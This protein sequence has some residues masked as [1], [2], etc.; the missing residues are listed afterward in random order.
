SRTPGVVRQARSAPPY[1]LMVST[2]RR[3]PP[4]LRAS[5]CRV[6]EIPCC[7]QAEQLRGWLHVCKTPLGVRPSFLFLACLLQAANA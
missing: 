7:F 3:N 5:R 4:T 2:C 6:S 1:L